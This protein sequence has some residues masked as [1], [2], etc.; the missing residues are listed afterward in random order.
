MR[1][2]LVGS[3][4]ARIVG[5]EVGHGFE[6]QHF[7]GVDVDDHSGRS[8]GVEAVEAGEE[9]VAERMRRLEVEGEPHRLQ[10]GGID[11]ETRDMRIGQ[12][13]LI[14]IFLHAGD[15]DVIL[16]DEPD[17]VRADR[18]VRINPLVL[19]QEADARQAEMKDFRLLLR[20][21]LAL[22]P[23]EALFRSQPL[24]QLLRVDVGEHGG[25]ELDRFVNVDD[26]VRLGEHGHGLDVGGEDGAVAVEQ[27]GPR[28]GDRII[29]RGFERLRRIMGE[30][31]R[32]QLRADRGISHE[33]A[34]REGADARAQRSSRV[35]RS[36][37]AKAFSFALVDGRAAC[38]RPEIDAEI[39]GSTRRS[40]A[41]AAS[42]STFAGL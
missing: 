17:H 1:L 11:S 42:A 27:I 14:E 2:I 26:A 4:V 5:I 16:V 36:S 10:A 40:R 31:E 29:G 25:D 41:I 24:A 34:E 18:S 39:L 13:L 15:A 6:R 28:A 38:T 12:A 8:L 3:H 32:E 22:D 35:D 23:D 21:D 19:R 37:R 20:R 7:T 30:A 33:Q 9:L